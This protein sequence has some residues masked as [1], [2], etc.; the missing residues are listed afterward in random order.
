MDK[1]KVCDQT[2]NQSEKILEIKDLCVEFKTVEGMQIPAHLT[3]H[4]AKNWSD[5]PD[6]TE[7]VSASADQ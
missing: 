6:V 2:M 3:T 5:F 7:R 1:W 4:S